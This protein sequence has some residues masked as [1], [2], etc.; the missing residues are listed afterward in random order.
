MAYMEGNPHAVR[1]FNVLGQEMATENKLEATGSE[2][3]I[4][5]PLSS[6][7]N[8]AIFEMDLGQFQSVKFHIQN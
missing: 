2:L 4:K 6:G 7:M 1:V 5:S 3:R 8:T